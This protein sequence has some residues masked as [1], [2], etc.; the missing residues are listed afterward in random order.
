MSQ[1]ALI[2]GAK[3]DIAR[4][5]A[6]QYA[7]QGYNLYLAGRPSGDSLQAEASDFQIRYQIEAKSIP[8]DA[9]DYN[10]HDAIWNSLQPQP[11]VVI[12][13]VGFMPEQSDAEKDPELARRVMETN[14]VGCANFLNLVAND[15]EKAKTGTIIGVSSVAG[16]RGRAKNYLYGSA[17]AAFSAYL[18]GL[19]N[20]LSKSG[21][22]VITV[23]PGFV[24]T[25]MTEHLDLKGPLVATPD[26]VGLDV[27]KAFKKKKNIIYTKWF[28]RYI[29][30]I[31]RNIPEGRFKKMNL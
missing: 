11:S 18:S 23:K 30:L 13:V 5:I 26:E 1:Y 31:I 28:W 22:H 21:V 12:C 15:F 9:L 4:A 7:A 3:S 8:F 27:W 29:M 19:R 14:Y 10:G 25:K 2:L 24:Q 20:R 6:R 17:K 16:D